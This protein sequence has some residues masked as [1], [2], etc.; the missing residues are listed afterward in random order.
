M[1]HACNIVATALLAG[2]TTLASA[3]SPRAQ[4][5]TERFAELQALSSNSA[6]FQREAIPAAK[7]HATS[8]DEKPSLAKRWADF[9]HRP[10]KS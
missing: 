1:K 6:R 4:D 10:S 5:F 3:Q 7:E 2:V 9:F 8:V